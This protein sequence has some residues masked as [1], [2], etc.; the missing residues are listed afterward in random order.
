MLGWAAQAIT[1]W[2]VNGLALPNSL[3]AVAKCMA[4]P[5]TLIA[6]NVVAAVEDAS[7]LGDEWRSIAQ[8]ASR[9]VSTRVRLW[10]EHALR[11]LDLLKANVA[12]SGRSLSGTAWHFRRHPTVFERPVRRLPCHRRS[13]RSLDRCSPSRSVPH[14]RPSFGIPPAANSMLKGSRGRTN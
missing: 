2:A 14:T 13:V 5:S 10:G 8:L 4:D 9:H 12:S 7:A 1:N 11:T 3:T 6:G